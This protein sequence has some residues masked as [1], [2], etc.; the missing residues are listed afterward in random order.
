MRGSQA[1]K[2]RSVS[3]ISYFI[4][5]RTEDRRIVRSVIDISWPGPKVAYSRDYII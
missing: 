1:F 3:R 4:A 5:V 2:T